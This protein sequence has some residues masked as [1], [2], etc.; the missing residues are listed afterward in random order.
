MDAR[1]KVRAGLHDTLRRCGERRGYARR[2]FK[3]WV[4]LG[5]WGARGELRAGGR[6]CGMAT[7]AGRGGQESGGEASRSGRCG[8][9]TQLSRE[10]CGERGRS[11]L[12]AL[13]GYTA[14]GLGLNSGLPRQLYWD[15]SRIL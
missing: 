15:E 9:I 12:V 10:R 7:L 11:A 6:V 14:R 3:L 4:R 8:A 13:L 2:A 5:G 1:E